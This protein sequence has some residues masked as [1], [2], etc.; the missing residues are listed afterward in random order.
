MFGKTVVVSDVPHQP[1]PST[2]S[3][4]A[5]SRAAVRPVER[6]C[7]AVAVEDPQHRVGTAESGEPG[8]PRR[9]QPAPTA[10]PPPVGI[11]VEAIE[12]TKLPSRPGVR[13]RSSGREADDPAIVVVHRQQ[14]V[15][16]VRA[17]GPEGVGLGARGGVEVGEIVVGDVAL[18]GGL[19]RPDV[20]VRDLEGILGSG[21]A[22]PHAR[23]WL[24]MRSPR[25]R[26]RRRG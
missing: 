6:L 13:G 20:D 1:G 16:N 17:V 18:V 19:P 26:R 8:A 24:P 5:P 21:T 3:R 9:D 10:S 12:L 14:R 11:D 25:L 4:S 7:S 23:L 2:S 15:G 22:D